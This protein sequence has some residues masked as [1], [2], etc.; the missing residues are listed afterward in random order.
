MTGPTRR[1]APGRPVQRR[2][3]SDRD[4][5][6]AMRL[7]AVQPDDRLA[8]VDARLR[9]AQRQRATHQFEPCHVE[10]VLVLVVR[11]QDEVDRTEVI[12]GN[13][14]AGGLG[15]EI[16]IAV[17]GLRGIK[18][19]IEQ[20]PKSRVFENCGRAAHIGHCHRRHR[21]SVCLIVWRML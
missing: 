10:V 4:V 14:G 9:G 18:R 7:P 17:V 5:A 19:G 15:E 6:D 2:R 11:K 12:H 21:L 1:S 3:R 8:E 20:D 13:A 16:P